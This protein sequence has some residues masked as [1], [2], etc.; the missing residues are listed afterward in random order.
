MKYQFTGLFSIVIIGLFSCSND[1]NYKND[2]LDIIRKKISGI[3][4]DEEISEDTFLIYSEINDE[5]TELSGVISDDFKLIKDGF[6]TSM[7]QPSIRIY[8]NDSLLK[9][10]IYHG[11]FSKPKNY[12]IEFIGDKTLK[13][14]GYK[15]FVKVGHFIYKSNITE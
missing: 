14:G 6:R 13:I 11:L 2:D 1:I 9:I 3:W 7:H 12:S 5:K 10:R 4:V 8:K 15:H